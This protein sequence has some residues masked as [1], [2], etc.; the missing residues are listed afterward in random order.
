[1]SAA[2]AA[3]RTAGAV[4][5]SGRPMTVTMLALLWLLSLLLY[6]GGGVYGAAQAGWTSVPALVGVGLSLVFAVLCAVMAIG[7]WTLKPWSRFLQIGIAVLGLFYCP[8]S[9]ASATVLFYMMREDARLYFSGRP[10][11]GS[12]DQARGTE[13]TFSL[14]LLGMVALGAILNAAAVWYFLARRTSL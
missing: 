5:S 14:S 1:M 6:L 4:R 8:F 12:D 13:L 2:A 10:V 9:L 7:L 3:S 11:P